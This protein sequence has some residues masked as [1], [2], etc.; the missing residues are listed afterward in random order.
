MLLDVKRRRHEI[1]I[2]LTRTSNLCAGVEPGPSI[3]VGAVSAAWLGIIPAACMA[4][5]C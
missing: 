1:R 3:R 2:Q 5:H 4:V